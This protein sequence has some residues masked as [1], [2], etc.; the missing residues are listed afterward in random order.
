MLSGGKAQTWWSCND[1]IYP[2]PHPSCHY[3]LQYFCDNTVYPNQA[4]MNQA[5]ASCTYNPGYYCNGVI[6]PSI[7]NLACS[8]TTANQWCNGNIIAP[9][10]VS[11]PNLYWLKIN[12]DQN[13]FTK[14]TCRNGKLIKNNSRRLNT[15]KCS[16]TLFLNTAKIDEVS[17]IK[18]IFQIYFFFVLSQ[19]NIWHQRKLEK[20][21]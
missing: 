13:W 15:V 10:G 20:F 1:I 5:G 3:P 17:N 2:Y 7:T 8:F 9:A 6:Y 16:Q 11:C 12:K 21:Q 14:W 19:V 18:D 4:A